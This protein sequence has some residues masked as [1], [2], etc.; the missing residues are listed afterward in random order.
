MSLANMSRESVLKA[1]QMSVCETQILREDGKSRFWLKKWLLGAGREFG[2]I[3]FLSGSS[4]FKLLKV[5]EDKK[6]S[7]YFKKQASGVKKCLLEKLARRQFW[8]SIS[9]VSFGLFFL[10]CHGQKVGF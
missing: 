9:E 6:T 3:D 4:F 1:P 7:F 2:K 8:K 10:G 5:L